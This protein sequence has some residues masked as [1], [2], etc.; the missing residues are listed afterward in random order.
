MSANRL[1]TDVAVVGA[2]IIG[3]STA[4]ALSE[5]GLK[6]TLIGAPKPGEASAAAGG[7]LAPSVEEV[8]AGHAFALASRD[9]YPSWVSWIFERSGFR[10]PLNREGILE[11]ALDEQEE[12]VLALNTRSGGT[13]LAAAELA[14][15]EPALRHARGGFIYPEDGAVDNVALLRALSAIVEKDHRVTR[16][17]GSVTRIEPSAM[18]LSVATGEDVSAGTIVIAAGAWTPEIGGLP[19][20]IPVKPVRG[21][22]ISADAA[23]VSRPV[24]G[25]GV[26]LVP[27][28]TGWTVIGSTMEHVGFDATN[29]EAGVAHLRGSAT[30]L[31]PPLIESDMSE[32]WAGLRPMTPDLLPIIDRDP[33]YPRILYA[34]G[35]SRNGILMA[36]LTA[37]CIASMAVGETPPHDLSPFAL[38]RFAGTVSG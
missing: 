36:P 18:T 25:A 7:L 32:A 1:T 15:L 3:L 20:V 37:D 8:S 6:V 22:M 29:T 17:V 5:A 24:F 31:C 33:R 16:L 4:V 28:A 30:R 12:R 13:W 38:S 34:C 14:A 10:V 26:Y 11:I 23:V 27:R 9:R 2:G 21:Q 19:T 35:H